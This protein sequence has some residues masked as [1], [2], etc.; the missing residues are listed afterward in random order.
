[1]QPP[2]RISA[3]YPVSD[4]AYVHAVGGA[5]PRIAAGPHQALVVWSKGMVR[6]DELGRPIDPVPIITGQSPWG[7]QDVVWAGD[8]Y[9]VT[10]TRWNGSNV[11]LSL[12][13]VGVEGHAGPP[14]DLETPADPNVYA[15]MAIDGDELA[16]A[17]TTLTNSGDSLAH[18]LIVS[19]ST[20]TVTKRIELGT[21]AAPMSAGR[22][23]ASPSGYLVL[24]PK[25]FDLIG[26][27]GNGIT[28]G[29][30]PQ[31]GL[32][33][34]WN[35]AEYIV[36]A[37]DYGGLLVYPMSSNG[38]IGASRVVD[39]AF[40]AL[41]P[42]IAWNGSEYRIVW[43]DETRLSFSGYVNGTFDLMAA[44]IAADLTTLEKSVLQKQ[45]WSTD[46][47]FVPAPDALAIAAAGATFIPVWMGG[48]PV[49]FAER[50]VYDASLGSLTFVPQLV[51]HRAEGQSSPALVATPQLVR[52][53][54]WEDNAGVTTTSIDA[55]GRRGSVKS[56]VTQNSPIVA[57][58]GVD[59]IALWNTPTN[60]YVTVFDATANVVAQTKLATSIDVQLRA[61]DCN[62]NDCAAVW[63]DNAGTYFQRVAPNGSPIDRP[64]P[65]AIGFAGLKARGNEYLLVFAWAHDLF[66]TRWADGKLSDVT[67][68]QAAA[69]SYEFAMASKPDGW[70]VIA[71]K[72]AIR[73]D[74][75]AQIEGRSELPVNINTSATW[76]GRDWIIAW[77]AGGDIDAVRMHPDGTLDTPF[78]VAATPNEE[79]APVVRSAGDGLTAVAYWRY[80][81]DRT[82]GVT[83]RVFVRWI[84]NR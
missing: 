47:R 62:A 82:Y 15:A 6:V 11:V 29:A 55:S 2:S 83:T 70:L 21:A 64:L 13:R 43:Q 25:H 35:G 77:N 58:N 48:A 18:A 84:D 74:A 38:T 8:E 57:F 20:F 5:R 50:D 44:R 12:M 28:S 78:A 61:F 52:V 19:R 72:D 3:E 76:D 24:T 54:W 23:V 39:E 32:D 67:D 36:A 4:V 81:N 79:S 53:F 51:S 27:H 59:T 60:V 63:S 1:M 49:V 33:A 16:I 71:G 9:L 41:T 14:I 26:L 56:N 30:L 45:V 17:Y 10:L 46:Y 40:H 66:A 80:T 7:P 69:A 42:A 31:W 34:V 37:A 75:N 65:L 68:L 22:V 73:L